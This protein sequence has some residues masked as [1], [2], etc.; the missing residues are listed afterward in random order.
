MDSVVD[1]NRVIGL[2]NPDEVLLQILLGTHEGIAFLVSKGKVRAFPLD[3]S[4]Q[5]AA[6]IVSEIRLGIEVNADGTL[7]D[8]DVVLAHQFYRRL[9]NPILDEINVGHIITVPT[10]ALLS[11]PFALLVTEKPPPIFNYDY[12]KVQWLARRS[13]ISLLPSVHSFV[14]LRAVAKAS[15]A[16]KAFIGFGD[17]VP[18]SVDV[19]GKAGA[20]IT[21]ECL[22]DPSRLE[23][24]RELLLRFP[25]LPITGIE[26]SEVAKTFPSN[27][28][29]I[30]VGA[31]FTDRAIKTLPLIDYK[32]LHFA[33]HG[34]LPTE[35]ECQ[36]WPALVTSPPQHLEGNDDGL[37]DIEE[38]L[39]FK[40]DADLVVLSACNTGGPGL[41]TGGESLSGLARSF[42]FAGARSLIVSHWLAEDLST[43]DLMIRTF[44][45]M[46]SSSGVGWASALQYAQLSLIEDANN[47][48]LRIRSHP[49][50]WAAF[51]VVGD[52]ARSL[53]PI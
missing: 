36:P 23:A 33:T 18:F 13:A 49:L 50:L 8:F 27:L 30:L 1:A 28:A 41:A 2:I 21:K 32:I 20:N 35:L 43:S 37:L 48:R 44:K 39:Q 6:E 5:Q 24:H 45:R 52:G 40:L 4:L 38:I 19:A 34:L 53:S 16:S 25:P 46:R 51:T 3:L 15:Q 31:A 11:L 9:F 14:G 7:P 22:Q 17:F 42:F 47:P 10:G 26:V 29:D 12:R